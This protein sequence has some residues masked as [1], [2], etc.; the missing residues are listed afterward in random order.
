MMRKLLEHVQLILDERE[1][2]MTFVQEE[3]NAGEN[4]R[5]EKV[6]K[7]KKEAKK[8]YPISPF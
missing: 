3:R 4:N 5:D 6:K 7:E 8:N 1:W 2:K